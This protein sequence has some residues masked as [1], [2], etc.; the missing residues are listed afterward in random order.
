MAEITTAAPLQLLEG[1]PAVHVTV[2]DQNE[3]ALDPAHLSFADSPGLTFAA[4]ETGFNV[5]AA[6]GTPAGNVTVVATYSGPRAPAAV[7]GDLA[8]ALEVT[9]TALRF[10]SP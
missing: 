8:I 9:V 2:T 7:T 10:T 1:G 4:D 5:T 3:V 6:A